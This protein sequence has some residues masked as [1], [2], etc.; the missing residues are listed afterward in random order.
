MYFHF[1]DENKFVQT[2]DRKSF[3]TDDLKAITIK[4]LSSMGD[5]IRRET[6]KNLCH[7][8]FNSGYRLVAWEPDMGCD[9]LYF[10]EVSPLRELLGTSTPD[11]IAWQPVGSKVMGIFDEVVLHNT[12]STTSPHSLNEL[13]EI[14]TLDQTIEFDYLRDHLC[15]SP[16]TVPSQVTL[17][18]SNIETRNQPL[19]E[20][21]ISRTNMSVSTINDH[22]SVVSL[23]CDLDTCNEV[24]DGLRLLNST[25][26]DYTAGDRLEQL[27]NWINK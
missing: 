15:L 5:G 26:H 21:R 13:N 12:A 2:S 18:E 11:V 17:Y 7:S 8:F 20:S 4:G 25:D 24:G 14:H 6:L 22:D 27:T 3:F 1:T 10:N 9:T 23:S 19:E 16:L